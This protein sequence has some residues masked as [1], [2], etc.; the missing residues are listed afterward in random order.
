[1]ITGDKLLHEMFPHDAYPYYVLLDENRKVVAFPEYK[2]IAE[3]SFRNLIDSNQV[4]FGQEYSNR[5]KYGT[6]LFASLEPTDGNSVMS[7]FFITT[8]L[9]G[10]RGRET[11]RV[12]NPKFNDRICFLNMPMGEII[13]ESF[14]REGKNQFAV[15]TILI[16]S[17]RKKAFQRPKDVIEF[18]AWRTQNLYCVDLLVKPEDAKNMFNILRSRIEEYFNIEIQIKK[19]S[20]PCYVLKKIPGHK[21]LKTKGGLSSFEDISENGVKM[22]AWKNQ[23]FSEVIT[24]LRFYFE[25]AKIYKTFVDESGITGNVDMKLNASFFDKFAD[26]ELPDIN[27]SLAEHDLVIVEEDHVVDAIII[28]DKK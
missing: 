13:R 1:M 3:K 11:Q 14:N 7:Y 16:E 4:N 5:H 20:R 19:I 26:A 18:D 25:A 24:T 15:N 12:R 22:M 8:E 17:S 9:K 2:Y 10:F 6:P 27:M 21:S 28:K 23:P